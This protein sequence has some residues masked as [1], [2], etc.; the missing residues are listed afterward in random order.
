MTAR[1]PGP[2]DRRRIPRVAWLV[3]LMSVAA[4]IPPVAA[5]AAP[6]P[7]QS[8]PTPVAV[9]TVAAA[10]FPMSV[11]TIGH[12]EALHSVLIRTQVTGQLLSVGFRQGQKVRAGQVIA[13]TDPRLLQATVAEDRATIAQDAATQGNAQ[14]VLLRAGPLVAKG[15]ISTQDLQAD[16]AQAAQLRAKVQADQAVLAR[17]QVQLG[18]TTITSPLDGI[19]GLLAVSPGN[20]VTPHDSGGIVTITQVEPI[21]AL[22]PIPG[23]TLPDVQKAILAAGAGSLAVQ[24]RGDDGGQPLDIGRLLAINNLVDAGS[25]TV[26]VAAEMPN[27]S[28]LLWPGQFVDVEL[29]LK[30]DDRAISVPLDAVQRD[31]KGPY[32]WIVSDQDRAQQARVRTGQSASTRVL[33]AS[34]LEVGDRIVTDGQYGLSD[35]T[36]VRVVGKGAA[37]AQGRP[38]QGMNDDRLGIVP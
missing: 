31:A 9:E 13:T 10:P 2:R 35:G 22:F 17:D 18:Y 23:S 25:G 29:V 19:A 24:V 5:R 26:T 14:S 36:P 21:L 27:R 33:I 38:M 20:V 30:V 37:P 4:M 15:L 8:Q 28:H 1:G 32:V 34:G 7:E 11:A 3:L 6:P 16:Q 12:V